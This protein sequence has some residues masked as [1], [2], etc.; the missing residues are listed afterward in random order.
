MGLI[1]PLQGM[2]ALEGWYTLLQTCMTDQ[3]ERDSSYVC[4]IDGP[5]SGLTVFNGQI[6]KQ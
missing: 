3:Y 2:L 6:T 4:R 5:T 1:Q